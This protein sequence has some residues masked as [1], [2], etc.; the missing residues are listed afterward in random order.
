[1]I[2]RGLT[3][4]FGL[5]LSW[6]ILYVYVVC[7]IFCYTFVFIKKIT[8]KLIDVWRVFLILKIASNTWQ[9][10]V[11]TFINKYIH[12]KWQQTWSLQTQNKL[13]RIYPTTPSYSTLSSS[14]LRK[15]QIIYNR[16]RIGHTRLTQLN[17]QILQNVQTVINSCLSNTY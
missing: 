4:V 14:S 13:C 15:D 1:M 10:L 9:F 5:S 7:I 8:R 16:L 3:S 11:T 17:T 2:S 6:A 12:D